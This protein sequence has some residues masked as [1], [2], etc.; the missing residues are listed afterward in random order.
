[1]G[2]VWGCV[3]VRRRISL[4]VYMLDMDTDYTGC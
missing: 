3:C 2:C 1:M 4:N